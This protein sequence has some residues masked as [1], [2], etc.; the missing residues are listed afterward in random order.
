MPLE[1]GSRL[2]PYEILAPLGTGGMGEVY[3]ARDEQLGREVAIKTLPASSL[4][5]ESRQRFLREARAASALNHP[6]IVTIHDINRSGDVDYMVMEYVRGRTLSALIGRRGLGVRD[7]IRYALQITDAL[8]KAHAAGIIHRDLKPGN[9]MVTDDGMVKVLDF[10]LAKI[11]ETE[12]VGESDAT[13]TLGAPTLALTEDG[14]VVGTVAYM[15]PEQAEGRRL[16]AR[17]DIFSLGAVLYEMV[18]GTRAFTGESPVATMAEILKTDPA[19]PGQLVENIPWDLDRIIMRCLRKD[20]S[21]RF[22]N[23]TDLKVDL[24]ELRESVGS[25][26]AAPQALRRRWLNLSAWAAGAVVVLTIV[27]VLAWM[28]GREPAAGPPGEPVPLTTYAGM[29]TN[30]AFSPD[31]SQVAFTWN[32]AAQENFDLYVKVTGS[33]SPV[34]LTRDPAPDVNPAWS[35]DGRQIAF[36]RQ[37]Q[38]VYLIPPVGG[39]ERKLIDAIDLG[40]NAEERGRGGEF[41]S[42]RTLAW[43]SDSKYLV[44][45]E[46]ASGSEPAGLFRIDVRNGE[47]RRITSAAGARDLAPALSP[48][49]R[50]LVFSRCSSLNSCVL[51]KLKVDSQL[52]PVGQVQ[53]LNEPSD[54]IGSVEWM[55]DGRSFVFD[56]L[57]V[58]AL[59][60]RLWRVSGSGEERPRMLTF[61]GPDPRSVAVS[62]SGGRMAYTIVHADRD[63]WRMERGVCIRSPLSSTRNEASPQFSPDGKRVTFVSWRSGTQ[64]VWVADADGTN[65]VQLT[66]SRAAGTPRW[67][68][69]GKRIVY[70]TQ[71]EDGLWDIEIIDSSGGNPFPLVHRKSDD[72]APSFSWDGKSV[73]FASSTGGRDEVYRVPV[74]GGEP[75]RVTDNGGFAAFESM[76]GRSIYYTKTPTGCTPLYVRSLKGGA[77]REVASSVCLRGFTVTKWGIYHISGNLD[78]RRYSIMLLDPRHNTSATIGEI[79]GRLYLSQ[80]LTVSP[81]GKTV[82]FAASTQAGGDLMLVENYR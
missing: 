71:G 53:S 7:C 12:E 77:E 60:S 48:D 3:L 59:T 2:G 55:P 82:L 43:S 81:D 79:E 66:F 70:D 30:P 62:R 52:S 6:G 54:F 28:R 49:G 68:P 14:T 47:S 21:R 4:G 10:G 20:P 46:A 8:A 33:G 73:Y 45:A 29:E 40:V 34:R 58:G 13:R 24:E 61:A 37:G 19:P 36:L 72:K 50:T 32:G 51:S 9:I 64:A 74:T 16:D 22:Q 11:G 78:E 23:L 80:G 27:L 25:G 76:D 17:S 67:S 69:D 57:G 56:E 35:P 1:P 15:S 18:T 38:G 75:V 44:F 63:L 31:G 65:A 39:S 41:Y 5:E 26:K 42:G